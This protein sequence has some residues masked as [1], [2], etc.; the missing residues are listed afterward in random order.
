M[1]QISGMP[2]FVAPEVVNKEGV[3][4]PAD[5][6][7]LGVITH[8][9]LTGI[10]LFRGA[11]DRTTLTNIKEKRWGF[12]EDIWQHLSSEARDFITRLLVYEQEGRMDVK[13]ALKHPWLN[14]ADKLP[15][16]QYNITTD[17]LR[18]YYNSLK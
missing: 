18:N 11:D 9:L 10:S 4:F 5:M 15:A 8:L 17:T 7:S 13:A 16:S 14:F 1:F 3:S 2:E 6:W 12:K